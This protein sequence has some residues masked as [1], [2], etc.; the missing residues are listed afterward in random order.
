M[1]DLGL[2]RPAPTLGDDLEREGAPGDACSVALAEALGGPFVTAER[3]LAVELRKRRTGWPV[4]AY[5]S[6]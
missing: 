2:A 4:Q 1:G 5:E 6:P 3:N